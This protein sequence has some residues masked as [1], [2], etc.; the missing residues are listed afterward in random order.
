MQGM[1][2]STCINECVQSST[3]PL[4]V[5]VCVCVSVCVSV[6]VCVCVCVCVRVRVLCVCVHRSFFTRLSDCTSGQLTSVLPPM[7]PQFY[8]PRYGALFVRALD[9]SRGAPL[10]PLMFGAQHERGY[11]PG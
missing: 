4:N 3:C 8:G 2:V 7:P 1:H 5:T 10:H 9:K 11:R 6:C